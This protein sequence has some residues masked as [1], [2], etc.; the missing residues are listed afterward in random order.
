[1]SD[2]KTKQE[3]TKCL[4]MKLY[5]V[6]QNVAFAVSPEFTCIS[7]ISDINARLKD[8]KEAD[9]RVVLPSLDVTK[10]N[11]FTDLVVYC[12]DSDV[13]PLLLYYLNELCS[14]TIFRSTN[15]DIR[16][17]VLHSHL[18]PE[19]C[20]SLLGFHAQSG[21]DQTGKIAEFSKKTCWT[22]LV[23]ASPDVSSAFKSV[24]Q[25][26]ISD[27]IKTGLVEFILNCYCKDRP[28]D[29]LSWYLF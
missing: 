19:L 5:D 2:I 1:M 14:S 21:C 18:V 3:L 23:D 4:S 22:V 17:R 29:S 28:S 7:N 20:T 8:H 26:E 9:T 11:P 13:L 25:F 27:E 6:F 15:R 16:L 24:G 12:C 10:R